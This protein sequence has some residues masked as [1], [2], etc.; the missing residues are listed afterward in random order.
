MKVIP[1][2]NKNN[3]EEYVQF[4]QLLLNSDFLILPTKAECYGVVFCEASAYGL[5]SIAND[6]GGVNGAVIDGENGFVLPPNS[7]ADDYAKLIAE[8]FHNDEK[9]YSLVKSSRKLFETKLNWDA[10]ATKIKKIIDLTIK[11]T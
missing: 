2:I 5:P 7:K 4:E 6:T 10:W 9:Y 11:R 1:F 8:I 3:K